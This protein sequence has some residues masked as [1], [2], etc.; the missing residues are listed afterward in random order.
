MKKM[1]DGDNY[2]IVRGVKMRC[3]K[4]FYVRKINLLVSYGLYVKGKLM[5][6]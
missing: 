6:N 1:S 5:M 4:G 3:N 2:Y